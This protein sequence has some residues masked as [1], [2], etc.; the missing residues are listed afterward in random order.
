MMREERDEKEDKTEENKR[1]KRR[2]EKGRGKQNT[3]VMC[4]V[5][6]GYVDS[7]NGGVGL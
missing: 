1:G 7:I 5:L 2:E 6:M 3:R 4:Q